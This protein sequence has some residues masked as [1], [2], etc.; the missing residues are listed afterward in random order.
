MDNKELKLK[1]GMTANVSI[2]TKSLK[3]VLVVPNESLRFTP[4]DSEDSPKYK[5]QGLWILKRQHKK[6]VDIVAGASDGVN[7][8]IIS[9]NINL[10]DEVITGLLEKHKKHGGQSMRMMG[11]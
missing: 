3:N 8:Q 2:L 11:P 6:R 7:T 9:G 10:G 1:P 4:F 5:Q